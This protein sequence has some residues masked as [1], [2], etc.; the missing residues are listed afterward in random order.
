[1]LLTKNTQPRYSLH[2]QG[3]ISP[4]S[5]KRCRVK[6]LPVLTFGCEQV[7][8]LSLNFM[9]MLALSEPLM[10]SLTPFCIAPGAASGPHDTEQGAS[11]H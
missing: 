11:S 2:L 6:T 4:D 9:P 8:P 5:D 7:K 1:M 3:I 10:L